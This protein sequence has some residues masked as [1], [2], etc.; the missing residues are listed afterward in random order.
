MQTGGI[1]P[2]KTHFSLPSGCAARRDVLPSGCTA[3]R[4]HIGA[5]CCWGVLLSGCAAHR[6]ALHVLTE[7]ESSSK[8]CDARLL[9]KASLSC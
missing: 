4:M 2:E 9:G 1:A 3:V 8:E 6:D 5:R 7:V